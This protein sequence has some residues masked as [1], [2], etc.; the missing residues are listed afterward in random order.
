M[1]ADFQDPC[2]TPWEFPHSFWVFMWST[3]IDIQNLGFH[4]MFP[5]IYILLL[6][7]WDVLVGDSYFWPPNRH[8]AT[9]RRR[10]PKAQL[11]HL[12]PEKLKETRAAGYAAGWAFC[13]LLFHPCQ[14][15]KNDQKRVKNDKNML[16]SIMKK[17]LQQFHWLRILFRIFRTKCRQWAMGV[18]KENKH[19]LLHVCL[20]QEPRGNLMIALYGKSLVFPCL[21]HF[22]AWNHVSFSLLLRC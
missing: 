9:S 13:L 8:I 15:G 1:I 11:T 5:F 12:Q 3:Y 21:H 19:D 2:S 6:H 22:D 20:Q 18:S 14:V 10:S 7:P 4:I 16:W 17:M